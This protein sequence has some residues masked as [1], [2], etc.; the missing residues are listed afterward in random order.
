M[1]TPQPLFN[2]KKLFKKQLG[3]NAIENTQHFRYR[4]RWRGRN[5][6][7]QMIAIMNSS[8]QQLMTTLVSDHLIS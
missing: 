1:P 5:K 3:T 2:L 7:M 4:Y 8:S 6:Q